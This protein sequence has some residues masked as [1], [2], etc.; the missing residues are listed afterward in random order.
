[1]AH[2]EH[3][4]VVKQGA[5]AIAEWRDS[6][7]G[8]MLDLGGADLSWA[9]LGGANLGEANLGGADLRGANLR[10]ANLYGANLYGAHGIWWCGPGGSRGDMLYVIQHADGPMV[11]TGCF[12]GT[13]EAFA[14][15]VERKHGDNEHGRYY[16]A[17]IG[18]ARAW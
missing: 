18:V 5:A 6:N 7:A 16:R 15:A 14:A 13:L 11:K 17:V 4:E 2:Q 3:V 1:M 12:W 8:V 10:A 9:D